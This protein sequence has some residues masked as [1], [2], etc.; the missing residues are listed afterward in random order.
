M[1]GVRMHFWMLV[2]VLYGGV[3][4]PRK[5]GH[6]LHHAGVDEQQVGVVEDHRG[7][8]HLG[9][10][11][12]HE[13]IEEPLPDLVCLHC[14]RCLLSELMSLGALRP[15]HITGLHQVNVARKREVPPGDLL[16]RQ[17]S[18]KLSRTDRR[19]LSRFRSTSTT[20]CQVPS[21]GLPA[22]TGTRHR[23]RDSAG[24]TWSA[25]WP[26]EPCAWR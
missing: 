14:C 18:T 16:C 23:G 10:T 11:R 3:R 26:G 17:P 15:D 13:V 24:S 19:G 8:G 5:Y 21:S 4:W 20:L 1:S 12:L 25:P 22:S 2:A 7:A 6:E 9:V